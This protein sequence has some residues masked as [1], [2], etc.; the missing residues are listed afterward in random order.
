[1]LITPLS[2]MPISD[3]AAKA[4]EMPIRWCWSKAHMEE[5]VHSQVHR[6]SLGIR[7]DASIAHLHHYGEPCNPGC[8]I[9]EPQ[10]QRL[11]DGTV[12]AA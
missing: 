2:E 10:L 12:V 8:C 4:E 3:D 9:L 11:D 6:H 5:Y 7:S 1:M